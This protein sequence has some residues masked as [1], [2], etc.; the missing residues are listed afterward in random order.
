MKHGIPLSPWAC[1]VW[2]LV[3]IACSSTTSLPPPMPDC[4]GG[5]GLSCSVQPATGGAGS[6]GGSGGDDSGATEGDSAATATCAAA[7]ATIGASSAL[8]QPCIETGAESS[9]GGNCCLAYSMCGAACKEI[10]A[11]AVL[12]GANNGTCIEDNCVGQN[13]SGATA[14]ND[15]NM[16]LLENCQPECPTFTTTVASEQ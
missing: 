12:C 9:T 3:A 1:S 15:F 8:C 6:A 16:C 10:I 11:C 13:P 5:K 14:F 4:Q 7:A 2:T